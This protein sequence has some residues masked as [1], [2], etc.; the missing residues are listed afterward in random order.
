[1][2]IPKLVAEVDSVTIFLKWRG[3]ELMLAVLK[4]VGGLDFPRDKENQGER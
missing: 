1:M 3:F 4:W 2:V